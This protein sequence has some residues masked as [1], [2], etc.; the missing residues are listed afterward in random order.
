MGKIITIEGLDGS[1]KTTQSTLLLDGLLSRGKNARLV[2]YP[3][4]ESDSSAL[5][6]MYLGGEFGSDPS[7]VN[8]YA[9]S[10]F[11]AVDRYAS[12]KKDWSE[13]YALPDSV[14]ITTR[15]TTANAI[16][17]LAKLDREKWDGF[18]E[19]LYDFEFVKLGI[20]KPDL[21]IYLEM[22][23]GI[24]EDLVRRRNRETGQKLDIHE[25]DLGYIANCHKAAVYAAEK[26][27][28]KRVRCDDG[29]RPLSVG[30][31]AE[32]IN[33]QVTLAFDVR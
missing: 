31:I 4:Y 16:H 1:G 19:W 23:T 20:P 15:Y 33:E 3:V 22:K 25:L 28:W 24:T 26:L 9:A 30:E 12:F 11:Y 14:M 8:A 27:G 6:R 5:V 17:Q 2:S 13:F 18:L 7:A 21:V 10:T 32:L 29:T